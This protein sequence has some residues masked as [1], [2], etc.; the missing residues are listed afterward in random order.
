MSKW[1]AGLLRPVS[2]QRNNI[3]LW[4]ATPKAFLRELA[5]LAVS[6]D[7]VR[8]VNVSWHGHGTHKNGCTYVGMH[9]CTHVSILIFN[10]SI[11]QMLILKCSWERFKKCLRESSFQ[12]LF[13]I[14][15]KSRQ[16]IVKKSHDDALPWIA[17]FFPSKIFQMCS[18]I[19]FPNKI[20]LWDRRKA[21]G[22][23]N[24]FLP[25]M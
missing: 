7:S 18:L 3:L 13:K 12:N 22:D 24:E 2:N 1:C 20:G 6:F 5:M 25:G 15:G 21:L 17:W 8:T 14:P 19:F 9:V 23:S 16:G 10:V 4:T 11:C